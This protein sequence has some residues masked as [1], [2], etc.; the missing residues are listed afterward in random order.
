MIGPEDP[1]QQKSPPEER[2]N[3]NMFVSLMFLF[4]V[5]F[6]FV[7]L[8]FLFSKKTKTWFQK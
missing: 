2:T 8:R 5:W 3:I 7:F 4:Y 1:K 6:F